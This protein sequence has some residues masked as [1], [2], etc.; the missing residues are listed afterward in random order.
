MRKNFSF[1]TGVFVCAL[2]TNGALAQTQEANPAQTAGD[3][4]STIGSSS[5]VAGLSSAQVANEIAAA[6]Q[7]L[8]PTPASV[9]SV[10]LA[11]LDLETSRINLLAVPKD[12]FLV[13]GADLTATT[14]LGRMVR[15]HVISP[16]GVNTAVTVNDLATGH[17][18]VPLVVKYPIVK[19]GSVAEAAYYSSAYPALLSPAIVEAGNAYVTTMLETAT[20]RLADNG[21][22]ISPDVV[23]IAEHLVIV[24]HIDHQRFLDRDS[25]VFSETLSLYALNQ[26]DTFRYSVSS[27]VQDALRS[28]TASKAEL[29][30][31][32]YNSNP[33]RLPLYLSRGGAQWRALIPAETQLYL[34]IYGSVDRN[35]GFNSEAAQETIADV[36]STSTQPATGLISWLGEK[37]L[38]GGSF[39]RHVLP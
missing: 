22:S 34:E 28:G 38:E 15:V 8:R 7:L 10:T 12:E 24:E 17:A 39:L 14:Q 18:F 4:T 37:L 25:K 16:N 29:L 35:V 30:V 21:V 32:G 5:S 13:K 33:F 19:N 36:S 3:S 20:K 27:E 9:G 23:N 6:K 26:G 2:F 31:A 1:L 11:A